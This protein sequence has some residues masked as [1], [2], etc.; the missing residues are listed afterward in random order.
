MIV[1]GA[2]VFG[3]LIARDILLH[4][5]AEIVVTSRD[6]PRA[7][8]AAC[9][10]PAGIPEAAPRVRPAVADAADPRSLAEALRGASVVVVAAGPFQ[11]LAPAAFDAALRMGAHYIDIADDPAWVRS[12]VARRREAEGAGVAALPGLSTV[13]GLSSALVGRLA[14]GFASVTSARI[15][16]YIGGANPR[17]EGAARSAL[18]QAGRPLPCLRGGRMR[19]VHGLA[20]TRSFC[21]PPPIGRCASL[22]MAAPD[23]ELLPARFP[24]LRDL[25]VEVAF[26]DPLASAA[27]RAVA[28]VRAHGHARLAA[29]AAALAL[30][31]RALG[32][33]G[34]TRGALVVAARGLSPSGAAIRRAAAVLVERE[35]QR[36]GAVPAAVG[37]ARLVAG[38][39]PPP[40]VHPL[41][42]WCAPE[43]FLA[44]VAARGLLVVE[45]FRG[46]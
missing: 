29:L 22:P 5:R 6:R 32:A 19:A 17:G 1:G 27:L 24:S 14:R 12:L 45:A 21:F 38:R 37:V 16:F 39:G 15:A 33:G 11:G 36:I 26:E 43:E 7:A 23:L 10:I 8:A 35:G 41:V 9:A 13:P 42:D 31:L 4:T 18:F 30:R 46:A 34:T 3:R 28:G 44:D 25:S 40:G 20:T 2:G